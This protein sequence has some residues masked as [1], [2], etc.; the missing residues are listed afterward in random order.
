[1]EFFAGGLLVLGIAAVWFAYGRHHWHVLR[2][3]LAAAADSWVVWSALRLLPSETPAPRPSPA[4]IFFLWLAFALPFLYLGSFGVRTLA[5]RRDVT[6][7]E[8]LQTVAALA[9]GFGGAVAVAL[10][11]PGT[12]MMLGG[13]ALAVAAGCYAVAFVFVE[14]Q[15]GSR[16]NFSFYATLAL[17]LTLSG[18]AL[19]AGGAVRGL[20]WSALSLASALLARRWARLTLAAHSAVFAV[21]GAWQTGLIRAAADAFEAPASREFSPVGASG[22]AVVVIAAVCYLLLPRKSG[23]TAPAGASVPP[24]VLIGLVI[25]SCGTLAIGALRPMTGG[26]PPGSDPG[27]MAALRTA[28]LAAA[29]FVLAGIRRR[30][31]LPELTGLAYAVLLLASV[32][33]LVED[34]PQGRASTL[35][36]GFVFYGLALLATPWLLRSAPASPG[37]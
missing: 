14:R 16:R 36:V 3:P 27:A 17:L 5:R 35:F 31:D 29:A 24:F 37:K 18:S 7:F 30:V 26:H 15:Q 25:A 13:S 4:I 10:P 8:A 21:A 20:F 11:F 33:L 22:L 34:L 23:K 12:R 28:V 9:I 19:L 6:G 2:W 32:K 1:V